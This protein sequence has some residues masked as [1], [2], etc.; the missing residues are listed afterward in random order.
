[1]DLIREF[2]D[3]LRGEGK[4]PRTVETYL[5]GVKKFMEFHK[6]SV[7]AITQNSIDRFFPK[8]Y[9]TMST[10]NLRKNS[11]TK[12]LTFLRTTKRISKHYTIRI[13][14]LNRQ[15]ARFLTYE[16]QR[17]KYKNP[18]LSA[19]FVVPKTFIKIPNISKLV[20]AVKDKSYM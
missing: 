3:S 11:I 1:M 15:E 18:G 19:H 14:N 9:P 13:K 12:F 10:Q 4:S 7:S 6:G 20:Y 5:T 2:E 16:K 17:S 8:F